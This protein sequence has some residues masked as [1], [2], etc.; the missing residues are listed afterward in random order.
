MG[1]SDNLLRWLEADRFSVVRGGKISEKPANSAQV[2]DLDDG[3]IAILQNEQAISRPACP[4]FGGPK[5]LEINWLADMKL[6]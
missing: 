2:E 4:F 5:H 1:R 6:L 3:Q